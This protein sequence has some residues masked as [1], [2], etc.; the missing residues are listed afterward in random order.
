V[1]GAWNHDSDL[2][3]THG[4]AELRDEFH[5]QEDLESFDGSIDRRRLHRSRIPSID[6]AC[7]TVEDTLP[8]T[9]SVGCAEVEALMATLPPRGCAKLRHDSIP[10]SKRSA[11]RTSAPSGAGS[12]YLPTQG[13]LP[14]RASAAPCSASAAP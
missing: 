10:L 13:I 1:S 8:A 2:H 9:L 11:D 3:G 14:R 5:Q 7:Q 4:M 12:P 6:A